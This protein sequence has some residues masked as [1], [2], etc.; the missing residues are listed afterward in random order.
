VGRSRGG[1]GAEPSGYRG[2]ALLA[3]HRLMTALA[4]ARQLDQVSDPGYSRLAGVNHAA[5]P[6]EAPERGV[7]TSARMAPAPSP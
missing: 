7:S 4:A 6:R 2:N 5:A 3:F 1:A